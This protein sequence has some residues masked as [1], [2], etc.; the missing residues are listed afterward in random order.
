[1]T[2][3]APIRRAIA[4][5][6]GIGKSTL[7][8]FIVLWLMAIRPDSR[9]TVTANTYVRLETKT[10]AAPSRNGRLYASRRRG[11]SAPTNRLYYRDAKETWCNPTRNSE[12]SDFVP[13]I[14]STALEF[15]RPS[16]ASRK[17]WMDPW[18]THPRSRCVGWHIG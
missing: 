16:G 3:V 14:S 10:W 17:V 8:A 6:H 9:G 18:R 7:T 11:S 4:S 2:L 12:D 1:V 15:W 13:P 5:G